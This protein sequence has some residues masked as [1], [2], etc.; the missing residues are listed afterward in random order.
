MLV[1]STFV[2]LSLALSQTVHGNYI[3]CYQCSDFEVESA[4]GV[5]KGAFDGK[6]DASCGWG[7]GASHSLCPSDGTYQCI[8]VKGQVSTSIPILGSFNV[9]MYSR[10][11]IKVDSYTSPGCLPKSE[12]DKAALGILNG[13]LTVASGF[14]SVEVDGDVC[15]CDHDLCNPDPCDGNNVNFFDTFCLPIWAVAVS[16]VGLVLV[17]LLFTCCCCCCCSCCRKKSPGRVIA[18]PG[19]VVVHTTSSPGY[20]LMTS[21][22]SE[23][24]AE[25]IHA[26]TNPG[27]GYDQK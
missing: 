20:A 24:Q 3:D 18:N 9:K 13:I 7:L 11:C 17:I 10:D 21:P 14:D 19:T 8:L 15:T 25:N 1:V 27:Y 22:V 26:M 5:F 12:A 16:A 4:S 2:L 6:S 23:T